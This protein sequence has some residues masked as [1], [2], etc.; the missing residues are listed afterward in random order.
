MA[1]ATLIKNEGLDEF[2][3]KTKTPFRVVSVEI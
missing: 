2:G 1:L 3:V